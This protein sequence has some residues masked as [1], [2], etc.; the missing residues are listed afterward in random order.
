MANADDV[1]N[2]LF[3]PKIGG[4]PP[5]DTIVVY[6]GADPKRNGFA[7]WSAWDLRGW[8]RQ[9]TWDLLRF[10]LIGEGKPQDDTL[11]M[12]L[13]DMVIRTAYQ[14][15]ENN[16]LLKQILEKLSQM[17]SPAESTDG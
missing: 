7:P 8:V 4:H 17:E 16:K 5:V 13:F 14:T 15:D 1:M 9:L 10:R 11:P 12:G 3:P 6:Q 2:V